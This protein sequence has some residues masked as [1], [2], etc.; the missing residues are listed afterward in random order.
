MYEPR[1][2]LAEE[3]QDTVKIWKH[4]NKAKRETEMREW[5]ISQQTWETDLLVT[6]FKQGNMDIFPSETA[7]ENIDA[8]VNALRQD[9]A[10]DR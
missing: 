8:A 9:N 4:Q 7:R 10:L 3:M 1:M 2:F 5:R 6:E